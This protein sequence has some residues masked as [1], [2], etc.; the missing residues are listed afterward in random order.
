MYAVIKSGGKQ[1][2]V[3]VGDRIAVE[4]LPGDVGET[5]AITDVLMIGGQEKP[6]VGSPFVKGAEVTGVITGQTK[7][8]KITI[9]KF[10]RR[11]GYKKKL[12][13]RQLQTEIKIEQIKG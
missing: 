2:R 6:A 4:K 7:A 12:G 11:G 13:H 8:K 1:Y 3:S 5:I 10:K 9:H